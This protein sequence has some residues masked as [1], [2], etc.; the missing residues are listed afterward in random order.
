LIDS[1]AYIDQLAN[2]AYTS[3]YVEEEF[4]FLDTYAGY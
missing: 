2:I 3:D 4:E 1:L